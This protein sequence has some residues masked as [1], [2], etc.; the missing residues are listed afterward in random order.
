M[1][2]TQMATLRAIAAIH[3]RAEVLE[4]PAGAENA[5]RTMCN[6]LLKHRAAIG[7]RAASA[8]SKYDPALLP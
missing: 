4:K 7:A 1:L 5:T 3:I 8:G 6:N 2:I